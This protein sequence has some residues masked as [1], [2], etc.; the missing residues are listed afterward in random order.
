MIQEA[1]AEKIIEL[2]AQSLKI[3]F[4]ELYGKIADIVLKQYFYIYQSFEDVI[5][6]HLELKT[7]VDEKV[8]HALEKTIREK[9]RPKEILIAGDLSLSVWEENGVEIIK[10]ALVTINDKYDNMK[11]SYLG[12]GTYRMIVKGTDYK[13]LEKILKDSS[14]YVLGIIKKYYINV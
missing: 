12:G 2:T 11:I 4:P 5:N 7:V 10:D 1:K 8:A 14:E 3:P 6:G 13:I 9:I